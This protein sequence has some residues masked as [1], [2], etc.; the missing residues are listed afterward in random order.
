[1]FKIRSKLDKYNFCLLD[2]NFVSTILKS[3]FP[4][5]I[6]DKERTQAPVQEIYKPKG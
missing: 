5:K 1:M 3:D 6:I 4:D 2:T